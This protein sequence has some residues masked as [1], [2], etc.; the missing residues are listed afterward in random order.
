MVV[1]VVERAQHISAGGAESGD[2]PMRCR[3]LLGTGSEG[4]LAECGRRSELSGGAAAWRRDE[5]RTCAETPT[6]VDDDLWLRR[7]WPMCVVRER[8]LLRLR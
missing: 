7:G 3:W 8:A 6:F 2:V 1:A 5:G 4:K